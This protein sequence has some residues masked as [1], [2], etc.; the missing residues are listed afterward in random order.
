MGINF[1]FSHRFCVAKNL[2][3]VLLFMAFWL[4]SSQLYAQQT[5]GIGTVQPNPRAA[6]DIQ[7]PN[8]NQGIL[9]P[10]LSSSQRSNIPA[11]SPTDD[12]E[13]PLPSD[14]VENHPQHQP[15][16]KKPNSTSKEYYLSGALWVATIIGWAYWR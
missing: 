4:I 10:R 14:A 3:V 13:R 6:L 16:Q 2:S 11:S 9:L 15:T 5:V 12:L 8:N 7:S 1:H